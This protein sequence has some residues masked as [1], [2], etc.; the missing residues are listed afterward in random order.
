MANLNAP[1]GLSPVMYRN[2]NYWNGQ[3]RLYMIS[4]S[5][6]VARGG[7]FVGDLVSIDSTNNSNAQGIP[8]VTQITAGAGNAVRGVIVGIG[9][10]LPQGYQGGPYINPNDLTKTF[11]PAGTAATDYIVAVADDPDII[12][13]VQEDTTST[14]GLAAAMTKNVSPSLGTPATG[15]FLSATQ[16]NSNTYATGA[17]LQL[18]VVQSIQ[19]PDNTPFTAYQKLLVL[20]NNHDF[21]GGTVGY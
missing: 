13:E 16:V 4:A 21:S 7:M 19:R 9:L 12:F 15:V 5:L 18:K 8:Y 11:R 6:S 14:P 1:S 17:T 20:I 10:A 2:G 3:A